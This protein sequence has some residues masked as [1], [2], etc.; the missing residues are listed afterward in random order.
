[1]LKDVVE[2]YCG[3][4]EIVGKLLSRAGDWQRISTVGRNEKGV[5]NIC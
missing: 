2:G 1:M 3:S 4:D 5:K